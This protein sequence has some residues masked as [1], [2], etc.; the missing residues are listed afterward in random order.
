MKI[1]K[2]KNN[3]G[4]STLTLRLWHF[5]GSAILNLII[6]ILLTAYLAPLS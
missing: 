1:F 2:G 6:L 3:L 4:E 5:T